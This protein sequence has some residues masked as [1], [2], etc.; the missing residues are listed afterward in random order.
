MASVQITFPV[1]DRTVADSHDLFEVDV[2]GRHIVLF[3]HSFLGLGQT[4]LS[5]QF[6]NTENCFPDGYQLPDGSLGKGDALVCQ[7]K[8]AKLV[9]KVYG[10][11]SIVRP[12]LAKNT[13]NAWYAIGGVVTLLEDKP[14]HF[15]TQQFTNQM[16]LERADTEACHRQWQD[17]YT[18][19]PNNEQLYGTCLFSSYYYAL[20][21]N[22]YGLLP[23]ELINYIPSKESLDWS[24][25]VILNQRH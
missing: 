18:E 8:I 6:L 10:V 25:G 2:Y 13:A 19:Y 7:E 3:A 24:L 22:G 16:L 15:E 17:L 4:L 20:M 9:D 23:E 21:V 5:Q 11:G 1:Q 14:I 12:A